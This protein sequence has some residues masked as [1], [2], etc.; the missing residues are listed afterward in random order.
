MKCFPAQVLLASCQEVLHFSFPFH[1]MEEI[2]LQFGTFTNSHFNVGDPVGPPAA[3]PGFGFPVKRNTPTFALDLLSRHLE[4]IKFIPKWWFIKWENKKI[5]LTKPRLPLIFSALGI[6]SWTPKCLEPWGRNTTTALISPWRPCFTKA[7]QADS[8]F[9]GQEQTHL[10]L[11]GRI[12]PLKTMVRS[13]TC[14]WIN[15]SDLSSVLLNW[16]HTESDNQYK[17][18]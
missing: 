2:H 13:A 12:V 9:P 11:P 10:P 17:N 1:P 6:G 5:T 8:Y 7:S 4:K 16:A 3:S 14:F 18:H 15:L